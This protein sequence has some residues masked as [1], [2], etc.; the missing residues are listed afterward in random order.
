MVSQMTTDGCKV[1]FVTDRYDLDAHE[2]RFGSVDDRLLARWT[3]AGESESV[4]YRTLAEWFNKRLLRVAYDEHGRETT[5][6]R[7]DSDYEAL[8]GDDDLVRQ[9]VLEDLAGDGIDGDRLVEDMVSWST[10]RTHLTSCLDGEKPTASGT[11]DWERENVDVARAIAVSNVEE[12][13]SSLETKGA[14][15]GGEAAEIQVQ[16]LLSCPDCPTRIPF[17]DAVERGFVCKDHLGP[18]ARS[19][20][21]A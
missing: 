9:E 1:E 5:G 18:D 16:V 20:G 8:T 19:G 15:P 12:A 10:L 6:T 14:L 11:S 4:G 21:G 17:A 13:V 7:V 3:G 2:S